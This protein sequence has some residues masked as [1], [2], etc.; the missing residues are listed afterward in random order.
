[1]TLVERTE[2]ESAVLR[3][4]QVNMGLKAGERLLVV[5]DVPTLEQW[6]DRDQRFLTAMTRR[7]V[8]AK[9]VAEIAR[10]RMM[11]VEVSL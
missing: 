9:T 3:M 6:S 7:A 11:G 2:I 1:M 4:L 5:T 10:D 8:L